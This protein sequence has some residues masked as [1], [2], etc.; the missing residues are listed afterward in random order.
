MHSLAF[1]LLKNEYV[2]AFLSKNKRKNN[3]FEKIDIPTSEGTAILLNEGVDMPAFEL[4]VCD[5]IYVEIDYTN[6][7]SIDGKWLDGLSGDFCSVTGSLSFVIANVEDEAHYL[8]LK[9]L[10]SG[11]WFDLNSP[12][13]NKFMS[14]GIEYVS[15]FVN[16]FEE[17]K[18]YDNEDVNKYWAL[19][20]KLS[21]ELD[22]DYYIVIDYL[23]VS[24][25]MKKLGIGIEENDLDRTLI[26]SLDGVV[27]LKTFLTY[28]EILY[29][30]M[31]E[32][33][34]GDTYEFA[35]SLWTRSHNIELY[36]ILDINDGNYISYPTL[37]VSE[38]MAEPETGK[39]Y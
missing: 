5:Y 1:L 21:D 28:N 6:T 22:A 35:Y 10:Y 20:K 37:R 9:N 7:V 33:E 16:E 27:D 2:D 25:A 17:D 3:I 19:I 11:K 8:M 14:N 13:I 38:Y 18:I 36:D 26:C 39:W 15:S 23:T 34:G 12:E 32:L 4:N 31:D 24:Y 29:E 30:E